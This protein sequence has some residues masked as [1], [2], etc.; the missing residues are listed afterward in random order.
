[1]KIECETQLKAQILTRGVKFTE[2]ALEK[3][4][5][6]KAKKQNR[7]YNLPLNSSYARPQELLITGGDGYQ[8]VVSCVSP[9]CDEEAVE[10]D[11]FEGTLIAIVGKIIVDGVRIEFV[12]EPDFYS[13]RL[14]AN[15]FVKDYVSAC[16]LDEMN[17]LPWKGCAISKGCRFCGVNKV[18]KDTDTDTLFAH[19]LSADP[20][21]W[22]KNKNKYLSNLERALLIAK[23]DPC[24]DT[25]KHLILISGNLSNDK[26]DLQSEIYSE[27]GMMIKRI[28][29]LKSTEGLIAVLMPPKDME[30]MRQLKNSG[31]EIVVFNLEVANEPWFSKYC[32][33][34]NELGIDFIK[35]RLKEAVN[36][37]GRGNVWTNFVLGLEPVNDLL[38]ECEVLASCGIVPGA[39]ILHLDEGHSLDCGVPSMETVVYFFGE[40]AKIYK[41]Y[42]MR[43]FYCAKALRTSLSNEAFENR[44]LMED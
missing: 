26:L 27:I 36:I 8:T 19:S 14:D 5:L 22:E 33:G 38:R 13:E 11:V 35:T 41:K 20:T 18:T 44:M 43:P 34:K 2:A 23:D 21:L 37:F 32:P 24:Y 39:N 6:D 9:S 17:I 16:G 3:A 15:E 4:E 28:A 10:I 30:K 1:M 25:H 7:V 42:D 29:H 31:I 40:L 12:R